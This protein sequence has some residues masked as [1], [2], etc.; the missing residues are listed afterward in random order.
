M[1]KE[2]MSKD[3]MAASG[4]KVMSMNMAAIKMEADRLRVIRY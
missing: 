4:F 2:R 3:S 1:S